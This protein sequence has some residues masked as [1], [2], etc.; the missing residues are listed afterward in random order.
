M[1]VN[2]NTNKNTVKFKSS[3]L[4]DH[5]NSR[6]R[7]RS[8]LMHVIVVTTNA[9]L[10]MHGA[11]AW[12]RPLCQRSHADSSDLIHTLNPHIFLSALTILI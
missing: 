8:E 4:N 2:N 9:V 10:R 7:F 11:S 6:V 12:A 3:R 5:V 1:D